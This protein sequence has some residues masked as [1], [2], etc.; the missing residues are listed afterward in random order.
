MFHR[1]GLK[2]SAHTRLKFLYVKIRKPTLNPS[3]EGNCGLPS[4]D[5]V[6]SAQSNEGII[7][8]GYQRINL[9]AKLLHLSYAYHRNRKD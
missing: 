7:G 2:S 6:V 3:R 8:V 1:R 9:M 5:F 4:W